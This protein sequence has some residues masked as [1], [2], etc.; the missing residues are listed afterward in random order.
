MSF[1]K[2]LQEAMQK[3]HIS[4]K[5]LVGLTGIGKSSINQY[6]HG[7]NEPSEERKAAIAEALGLDPDYF[8]V[9][10]PVTYP[11]NQIQRLTVHEAARYLHMNAETVRNGLKQGVFP[12]GYAI[13]MGSGKYVYFINALR[14]YQIEG[15][16]N[17]EEI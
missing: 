12:W 14:F 17:H 9:E 7:V 5:Q 10:E 1:D 3:L 4:Q 11:L 16:Y 6:V 8:D 15:G 2:R 13:E